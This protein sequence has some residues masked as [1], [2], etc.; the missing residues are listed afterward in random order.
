MILVTGATGFVGFALIRQ[1]T[2]DNPQGGVVVAVRRFSNDL[3]REVRQVE[4]GDLRSSADWSLALQ[5]V[6]VV[7]HCAA[8][9]HVMN[10]HV[11][12]PLAAF[13]KV[14]VQGT[15]SLARQ[16]AEAGV[17]RF[18]FVSSVKVNGEATQPGHPFT[19]DGVSAPQDPYGVSKME[20]EEGLR[21]L[22]AKTGMEVVII[23]PPLVYGFGVKANFAS[24][25]RWLQRGVPLPLGGITRNR[26]SLVYIGNLVDLIT[27]CIDH[28][29]AAN[30]TFLVSDDEDVST[31]TLLQRMAKALECP[32]RLLNFSP[33]LIKLAVKFIGKPRVADRLC[34]SLQVDITKTKNLLGWKPK[35]SLDEGLL[36]T[37]LPIVTICNK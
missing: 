17:R 35:F 11:N 21:E 22:S 3:P 27:V 14:N 36:R 9:V 23:R 37:T 7:I 2:V 1:L 20:A 18:L 26:R 4:V 30:Q 8:R 6:D 31:S 24:M 28:P 19:A 33:T 34:G 5:G 13:R 32:V 10:E 12:D 29:K 16:A 15:L 25:M